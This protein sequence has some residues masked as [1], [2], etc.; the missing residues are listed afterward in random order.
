MAATDAPGIVEHDASPPARRVLL[1]VCVVAAIGAFVLNAAGSELRHSRFD[2]YVLVLALLTLASRRFTIKVPGH[3]ATLSVSEVFVFASILLFGP[4]AATFTVA[5]DGL[6]MSLGQYERRWHRTIF[7]V[8]EPAISTWAAGAT[9]FAIAHAAPVGL[10]QTGASPLIVPT[11][12]MVGVFFLLNGS[13]T[14]VAVGLEAGQSPFAVWRGY[15][16][17]LAINY[18]ASASVAAIAV[19]RGQLDL[20]VVGLV[21]PLLVLSYYTYQEASTR[22]DEAER[23]AREVE[24]L[25]EEAR[26]RDE[27]LRQA[28]KLEAVGRLAG[29][30]AHD[31]NNMLTAITGYGELL[32]NNLDEDDSR[33]EDVHEILKAA[34]RATGLTRQLLAFSRRQTIAPKVLSL[35]QV[36]I[37]TEKMLRRLLGEDIRFTTVA[38]SN[39]GLVRADA[40]QIEQVLLNLAVNARDAMP[41]GGALNIQLTNVRIDGTTVPQSTRLLP[42]RYVRLSVA[43]TGC[44]MSPEVVSRVFEPFFTTK[45]VGHG[46]GLGL[47]TVYGIVTQ[48]GGAIQ[49]DTEVGRGTTFHVYFPETSAPA[50][51][52]EQAPMQ[53]SSPRASGTVLVVEDETA[54]LKLVANGLRQT[55]YT[56]LVAPNADDAR[57][58]TS[59]RHLDHVDGRRVGARHK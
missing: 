59:A 43:D 39:L 47:A 18:Y 37:D 52:Q 9:F 58:H 44:G 17:P 41:T 50:D 20:Q 2:V 26:K 16:V 19:A 23:H 5:I 14:A 1:F 15:A 13:L 10:V 30:V 36:V 45:E 22:V 6:W 12:G 57:Q 28:Q 24:R 4:A 38:E 34:A 11:V 27:E 48:A 35:D 29:G 53:S 21:I 3:A 51:I 55:G 54:V 8:A 46:T 25:Y 56:V 40:G 7:N 32:V 49:I 31:F 33:R 42:G